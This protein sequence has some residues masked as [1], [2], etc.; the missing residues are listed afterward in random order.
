MLYSYTCPSGHVF[1][2][3]GGLD[4][5]S[6]PCSCG[7]TAGRAEVNHFAV[8]GA[9]IANTE[10]QRVADYVESSTEVDYHYTKAEN[11]GVPVKRP[12]LY[13]AAM[14]QAQKMGAPVKRKA[15]V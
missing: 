10:R 11:N 3:I 6:A 2:R 1:E 4:A 5:S 13:Q 7:L 12:N 14:K 8:V 9:S 15:G